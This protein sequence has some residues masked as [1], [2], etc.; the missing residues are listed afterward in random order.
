M[1]LFL[2]H[3]SSGVQKIWLHM[4]QTYLIEMY[5]KTT[6]TATGRLDEATQYLK[7][8][9]LANTPLVIT[10]TDCQQPQSWFKK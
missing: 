8:K 6:F 7:I 3:G 10:Q 5:R 2:D 1:L 4:N 9:P